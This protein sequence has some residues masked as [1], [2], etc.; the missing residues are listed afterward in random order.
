MNINDDIFL[1][2][3][4]RFEYFDALNICFR[5]LRRYAFAAYG[6]FTP[7]EYSATYKFRTTLFPAKNMPKPLYNPIARRLQSAEKYTPC[8]T[9]CKVRKN[10]PLAVRTA[11][12]G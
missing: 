1:S 3:F 8:R 9:D 11:K 7:S 5:Y 4:I 2:L 12:C 6:I 10:T